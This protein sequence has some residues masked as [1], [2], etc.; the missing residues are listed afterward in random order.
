MKAQ[1]DETIDQYNGASDGLG[2]WRRSTE[3]ERAGLEHITAAW[4]LV[5]DRPGDLD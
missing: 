3:I 4:S 5:L 2:P 1:L